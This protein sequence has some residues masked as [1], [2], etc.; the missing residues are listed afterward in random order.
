[1]FKYPDA[2]VVSWSK[3]PVPKSGSTV[4]RIP[5]RPAPVTP[6]RTYPRTP[7][8]SGVR[9]MLRM[10]SPADHTYVEVKVGPY[11]RAFAE[12]STLPVGTDREQNPVALATAG[13]RIVPST[14]A[15]T[16][17]PAIGA[18]V[19]ASDTV[20]LIHASLGL[21]VS[22]MLY[23][24]TCPEPRATVVVTWSSS[25]LHVVTV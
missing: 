15:I 6:S 3:Y 25:A 13:G 8:A 5:G 18:P 22:G 16:V 1:M 2:S 21:G 9:P 20:P 19:L 10:Y 4:T 12:S 7:W 11:P 14:C 23:Q 17:A 24:R